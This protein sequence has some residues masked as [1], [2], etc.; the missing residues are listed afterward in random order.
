MALGQDM[1]DEEENKFRVEKREQ[2]IQSR[3]Q[4]VRKGVQG[5]AWHVLP[6][7]DWAGQARDEI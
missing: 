7:L 3:E 1:E 4:R 5:V 2:G 6:G